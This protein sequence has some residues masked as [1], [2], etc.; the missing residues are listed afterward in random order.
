MNILTKLFY[1]FFQPSESVN[2]L[3]YVELKW[4]CVQL[5]IVIVLSY[6]MGAYKVFLIVLPLY[7]L[8]TL[9]FTVIIIFKN[10]EFFIQSGFGDA[11]YR[12]LM[13][14][15]KENIYNSSPEKI[16]ILSWLLWILHIIPLIIFIIWLDKI[17]KGAVHMTGVDDSWLYIRKNNLLIAFMTIGVAMLF[18]FIL[19]KNLYGIDSS[20]YIFAM[21]ILL[22]AIIMVL[23]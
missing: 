14:S 7:I 17:R 13:V 15:E 11:T 18:L 8:A 23:Y 19:P 2:P 16:K 1:P 3:R 21:P 9:Y 4:I 6:L 5:F 22:L 12:T 10:R 20:Y